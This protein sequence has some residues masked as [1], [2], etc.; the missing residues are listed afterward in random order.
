LFGYAPQEVLGRRL[1][2]LIGPDDP[3]VEETSGRGQE[4]EGVRR[5]KDGTRLHVSIVRVPVVVPGKQVSVYAIYRDIGDRKRAEEILE[6]F[7]QKLIE[8]QEGERQ[9]V[10]RELHDEIGQVLTAIRLNLN[11]VQHSLNSS[12]VAQKLDESMAII[13]RALQQVRELSLDLRP[14]ALDDLGLVAALR[15]YVDREAQRR[16]FAPEF[17][18]GDLERLPPELETA[19]FRIAQEALTNVVRH[20][21]AKYVRV[22][23]SQSGDELHLIVRDDGIGFD[24]A[25]IGGSPSDVKLGLLGMRERALIVGGTIEVVSAPGKGTEVHSRFPLKR[26]GQISRVGS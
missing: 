9:R 7:S 24:P 5:R 14:M 13:D 16:G 23:L 11:A 18:A 15:W 21:K 3:R 10:A 17:S 4:M 19:C 2:E 20:A 26:S 25:G 22:E 6:T 8:T 12:P 1:A